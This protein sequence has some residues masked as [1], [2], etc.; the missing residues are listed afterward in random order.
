MNDLEFMQ[1]ERLKMMNQKMWTEED[2]T[3]KVAEL[4][5]WKEDG[6]NAKNI[7]EKIRLWMQIQNEAKRVLTLYGRDILI[8]CEDEVER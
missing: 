7:R 8:R 4:V 1:T 6:G 5:N 2:Y 3:E